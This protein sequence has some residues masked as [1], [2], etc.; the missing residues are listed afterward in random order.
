M[1]H[2]RLTLDNANQTHPDYQSLHEWLTAHG[3]DVAWV[4]VPQDLEVT[5]TDL[6]VIEYVHEA[7][8][9]LVYDVVGKSVRTRL[10]RYPRRRRPLPKLTSTEVL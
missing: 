4:Q 1:A 3:V 2:I 8:G 7:D 6:I 9:G 10:A 5:P